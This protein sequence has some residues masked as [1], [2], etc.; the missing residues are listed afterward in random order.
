[1][2]SRERESNPVFL[3]CGQRQGTTL[4]AAF[5][6]F[7]VERT[8]KLHSPLF[9]FTH[10]NRHSR[11]ESAMHSYLQKAGHAREDELQS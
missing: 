1:M 4:F 3:E 5:C 10:V 8:H 2:C 7:S 6:Q 9:L 11:Y